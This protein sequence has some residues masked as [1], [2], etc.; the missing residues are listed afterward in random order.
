MAIY[1]VTAEWTGFI[2]A[3]GYTNFHFGEFTGGAD[4][5]QMRNRVSDFFDPLLSILSSD[6]VITIPPTVEVLDEESGSLTGY[7]D[8]GEE[9]RL[10][11]TG[12]ST[13]Y[14]GPSG[15]V[16]NWITGTVRNGRR[17]MGR[18]FLVPLK[19]NTYQDDG[20]LTG[21][22]LSSLREAGDVLATDDFDSAFG[23]WSRP[24]NGSG[25]VLAPVTGYRVPDMVAVL[26]SR[27][28]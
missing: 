26:R 3:P 7:L 16:I 6:V 19:A 24:V 12:S 14:A 10:L 21:D 18:T 9:I 25:G 2:G 23:V 17:V 20:T 28:D 8:G 11:T 5:D 27:R 4:A 1:R 13:S 22:A 15:A